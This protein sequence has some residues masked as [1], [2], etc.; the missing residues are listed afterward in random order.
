MNGLFSGRRSR[1]PMPPGRLAALFV[2]FL[3]LLIYQ[4]DYLLLALAGLGLI[5]YGIL[6][7]RRD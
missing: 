2:M 1:G 7:R 6:T 4:R 5:V 3:A